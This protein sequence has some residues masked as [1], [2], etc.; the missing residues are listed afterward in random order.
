MTGSIDSSI[1]EVKVDFPASAPPCAMV[2]RTAKPKEQV[3]DGRGIYLQSLA[4]AQLL[5]V[6]ENDVVKMEHKQP[7]GELRHIGAWDWK[8]L[9]NL[10]RWES[11]PKWLTLTLHNGF[12]INKKG[13]A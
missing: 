3:L 12:N 1:S 5:C 4:S 8:T 2:V 10:L 6:D 9:E 7:P 13:N 11:E